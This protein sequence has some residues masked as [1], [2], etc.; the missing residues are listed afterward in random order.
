M[1]L[2]SWNVN[3][4]RACVKKDFMASFAALDADIF[5][6]QETKLQHHAGQIDLDLPGYHQ[7]WN[8]AEKKGYSGVAIFTKVEPL[9]VTYGL[10]IEEHDHEGRVITAEFESFYLVCCYTPNSKDR[11]ARLDYRMEWEDDIRAY[12]CELDAKKPVVYCG[13]LNVAHEEIDIKNPKSNRMNPGFSDEERAKMTQLL[14]SGF[15]D[16]F[17]YLYPDKTGAYSWWSYRF[18]ARKN[19]AGWRID[20]FIV[21]DRLR[22]KIRS[23][24]IWSEVMGSDHCPVVLEL[25]IAD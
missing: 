5:C 6:V 18:N 1:K 16:T 12:L 10:G 19:N 3:G 25:D 15:T 4:L 2:I 14:E 11:L 23:A 21:S 9:S 13:D 20:Y 17:R 8:S 24:D 7:F 22:D